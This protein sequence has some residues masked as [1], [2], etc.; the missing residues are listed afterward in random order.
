M[1]SNPIDLA[2]S[3]PW[4]ASVSLPVSP[5]SAWCSWCRRWGS[6]G[7][8]GRGRRGR[9]EPP[10]AIVGLVVAALLAWLVTRL[11]RRKTGKQSLP[12]GAGPYQET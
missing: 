1:Q 8:R 5:S 10:L 7:E 11:L 6:T 9:A 4:F 2:S 12:S 3:A